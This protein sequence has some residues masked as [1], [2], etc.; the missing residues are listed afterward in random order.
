MKGKHGFLYHL[1]AI[2]ISIIWGTTFASTKVLITNGMTPEEIFFIRFSVA[3]IGI[4][5]FS[6]RKIWANSKW[7]EFLLLLVGLTGGSLYFLSENTAL[8]LTQTT[9][10]A[11]IV[12]TAPLMTTLLALLFD[13]DEKATIGIITGSL[14]AL[15]GVLLVVFNGH[16]I[17]KLSPTGD[18]LSFIAALSWAFYSLLIKRLAQ[19]YSILFISR[20]VFFYGLVTILPVFLFR[21]PTLTLSM[22]LQPCILY[23]LIYLS[24]V[25][26]LICFF[27]WNVVLKQL[28]PLRASNYIYLNPLVASLVSAF[29]L[30]ERMTLVLI[31]GFVFIL[32]GIVIAEKKS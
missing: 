2:V 11:F 30:N 31:I 28:G 27:V 15:F 4:W 23:N 22:L 18:L 14:M 8:G 12:C 13:K 32:G 5:F 16:F 26:S 24:V 19:R 29:I 17:L 1:V 6:S 20:K 9:N 21:S 7:D 3:Y 25:A 10:V